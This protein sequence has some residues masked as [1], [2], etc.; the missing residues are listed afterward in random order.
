[1][2]RVR[3]RRGLAGRKPVGDAQAIVPLAQLA[4]LLFEAGYGANNEVDRG[5]E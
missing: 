3:V 4:G 1:M 5:D 2:C